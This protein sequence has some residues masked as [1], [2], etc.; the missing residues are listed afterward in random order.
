MSRGQQLVVQRAGVVAVPAGAVGVEEHLLAHRLWQVRRVVLGP[1]PALPG[2][3]AVAD[4][5]VAGDQQ[6]QAVVVDVV[7]HQLAGAVDRLLR[8]VARAS[9]GRP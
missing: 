4:R 3:A 7:R 6:C 9:R 5:Q 2:A 1:Q 8:Q